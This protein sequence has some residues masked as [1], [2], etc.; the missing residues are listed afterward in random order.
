MLKKYLPHTRHDLLHTVTKLWPMLS[1]CKTRFEYYK[2]LCLQWESADV[3]F[4]FSQNMP[5]DKP[6]S[7]WGFETTWHSCAVI[8]ITMLQN[9]ISVLQIISSPIKVFGYFFCSQ[10]W[11][12]IEQYVKRMVISNAMMLVCR[13]CNDN[14]V[15]AISQT[16]NSRIAMGNLIRSGVINYGLLHF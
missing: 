9:A 15:K 6:T 7:D 4:V 3:S 2:W 5:L 10:S 14:V 12:A 8:V 11:H 13:Y 16:A 1:L